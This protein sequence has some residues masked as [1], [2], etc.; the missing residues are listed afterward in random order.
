MSAALDAQSSVCACSNEGQSFILTPLWTISTS[1]TPP[2]P[3]PSTYLPASGSFPR[4]AKHFQFKFSECSDIL[5]EPTSKAFLFHFYAFHAI[6]MKFS[7]TAQGTARSRRDGFPLHTLYRVRHSTL[8]FE[9]SRRYASALLS[10]AVAR[11]S[12][13]ASERRSGED[14]TKV[15]FFIVITQYSVFFP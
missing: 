14:L 4:T 11:S 13:A 5:P 15:L 3:H 2:V 12:R 9:P 1:T 6:S 7:S 8:A 10:I